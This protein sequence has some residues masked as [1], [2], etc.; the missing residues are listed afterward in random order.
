MLAFNSHFG[1]GLSRLIGGTLFAAGIYRIN[2][3]GRGFVNA[4][5]YRQARKP[6][7]AFLQKRVSLLARDL[8]G[9]GAV[10]FATQA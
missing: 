9:R 8:N 10:S 7:S 2:T 4:G 1:V 6:A 5:V 3:A